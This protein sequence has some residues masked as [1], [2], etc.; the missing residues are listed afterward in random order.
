MMELAIEEGIKEGVTNYYANLYLNLRELESPVVRD[1][2]PLPSQ[3]FLVLVDKFLHA[4][5]LPLYALLH[6]IILRFQLKIDVD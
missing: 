3:V 2:L 1:G 5:L 4:G 6:M